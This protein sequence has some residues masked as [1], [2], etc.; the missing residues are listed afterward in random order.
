MTKREQIIVTIMVLVICYGVY[1]FLFDSKKVKAPQ[2]VDTQ[3]LEKTVIDVGLQ[4]KG[5][6][7]PAETARLQKAQVS[8]ERDPF[9]ARKQG[10]GLFSRFAVAQKEETGPDV[11]FSY[12]G[13]VTMGGKKVAVINGREYEEGEQLETEGYFAEVIQPNKVTIVRRSKMHDRIGQMT[14][15]LEE[16]TVFHDPK[17]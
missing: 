4:F 15:P 8:W 12:T 3:A 14:L 1:S 10:V 6:L 11:R 9:Y 2:P 17:P 7:T 5:G 16:N 13:F